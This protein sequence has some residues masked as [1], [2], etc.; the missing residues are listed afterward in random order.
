M[1]NR[2]RKITPAGVVTSVAGGGPGPFADGTG[3]AAAFNQPAALAADPDGTLYVADTMNN[4]IR[5]VSTGGDVTTIAGSGLPTFADGDGATS[6]F[7]QPQGI[8][9]DSSGV[10]YIGDTMNARIRKITPVGS[11]GELRVGW[12][13]PSGAIVNLYVATATAGGQPSKSCNTSGLS[14]TITGLTSAVEYSITVTATNAAG[15]SP[16]S[17]PV[18]GTPN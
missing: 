7:N 1:N 4:R 10:L 11:S 13:A 2:I 12:T 18:T 17:A 8:A 16:P 15:T 6:A 9:V 14:C 5:K 3:A